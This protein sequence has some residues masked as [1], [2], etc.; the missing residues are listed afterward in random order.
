VA[1]TL[2]FVLAPGIRWWWTA[3]VLLVAATG[4]MLTL[5]ILLTRSHLGADGRRS[6]SVRWAMFLGIVVLSVCSVAA[7]VEG[8]KD[9]MVC[10]FSLGTACGAG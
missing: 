9:V 7:I 2:A 3:G 1:L 6:R 8:I 5:L 4:G 10:V